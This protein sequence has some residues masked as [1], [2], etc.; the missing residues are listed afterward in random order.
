MSTRYY[1]D[2]ITLGIR[3]AMPKK[4]PAPSDLADKFMLRLPDG[5]RERISKAAQTNKRSMNSE[6]VATLQNAYP[7][8]EPRANELFTQ[9]Y[10]LADELGGPEKAEQMR[11]LLEEFIEF[12][13]D[14]ATTHQITLGPEMKE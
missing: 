13:L 12:M 1:G 3:G 11:G 4:P 8:I 9:I 6:I 2:S 7:D 10:E 5:L 14:S